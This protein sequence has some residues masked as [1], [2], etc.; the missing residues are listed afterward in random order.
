[1]IKSR[2]GGV[3]VPIQCWAR[4]GGTEYKVEVPTK[5]LHN[6]DQDH[7]TPN[8]IRTPNQSRVTHYAYTCD[9]LD[10]PMDDFLIAKYISDKSGFQW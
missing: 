4:S 9:S 2:I 8:S 1:V 6:A 7:P 5:P 3:R 10:I